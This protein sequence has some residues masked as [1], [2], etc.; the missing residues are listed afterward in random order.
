L[1]VLLRGLDR[2]TSFEHLACLERRLA[3]PVRLGISP[4]RFQYREIF[5]DEL[6]LIAQNPKLEITTHFAARFAMGSDRCFGVFDG[7]LLVGYGFIA[8]GPTQVNQFLAIEF[9]SDHHYIYKCFISPPYRGLG[10]MGQLLTHGMSEVSRGLN[11]SFLAL[12]L[13]HNFA[14]LQAFRNL[15]FVRAG[16]V[17]WLHRG[18][19]MLHSAS[20]ALRSTGVTFRRI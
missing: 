2:V 8:A 7:T 15:G 18:G 19:V 14:A 9:P 17:C 11:Q 16:S 4:E 3:P 5:A 20:W 12:V 1:D 6:R 13:S 10:A